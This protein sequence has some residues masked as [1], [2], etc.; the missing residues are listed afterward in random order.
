[1]KVSPLG[2]PGFAVARPRRAQPSATTP[3]FATRS[4][5][6]L[7]DGPRSGAGGALDS[8]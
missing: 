1:V 4:R 7:F 6:N 8:G 5:T 2:G 3:G